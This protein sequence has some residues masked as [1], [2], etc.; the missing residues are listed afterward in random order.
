MAD[1]I[2][3]KD[4][5]KKEKWFQAVSSVVIGVIFIIVGIPLW[6]HTTKVY[7]ATLPYK[8]IEMLADLQLSYKVQI[9][10]IIPNEES[11]K[12]HVG[13]IKTTLSERLGS[14]KD[15]SV[16][17]WFEVS[18]RLENEEERAIVENAIRKRQSLKDSICLYHYINMISSS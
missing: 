17:P 12:T 16:N 11:L 10:I 14:I 8:D 1:G 3:E 2:G 4:V 18:V 9:N 13:S 7:R 15:F 6:W 5:E